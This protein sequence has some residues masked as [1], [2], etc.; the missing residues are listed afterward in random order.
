LK[1]IIKYQDSPI[2][3]PH[4]DEAWKDMQSRLKGN[5]DRS[6]TIADKFSTGPSINTNGTGLARPFFTRAGWIA[7]FSLI[8][9]LYPIHLIDYPTKPINPISSHTNPATSLIPRPADPLY[10]STHLVAGLPAGSTLSIPSSSQHHPTR[11][12]RYKLPATTAAVVSSRASGDARDPATDPGPEFSTQKLS[13][14]THP[15]A[16]DSNTTHSVKSPAPEIQIQQD[17][18]LLLQAGL[19]WTAQVPTGNASSYFAGTNGQSRPYRVLLPALWMH[20]QLEKSLFEIAFDPFYSNMVPARPFSQ[21]ISTTTLPDTSVTISQ[22]KT[23]DKLFGV[24]ASIGYAA[25]LGGNWWAGGGIQTS[26]WTQA[27]ATT[28]TDEVKEPLN[29][30]SMEIRSSFDNTG[31]LSKTD[32]NNFSTF[33]LNLFAQLLYNKGSWHAGFRMGI[34]F[35]PLSKNDG[36]GSP[37]RM[38]FFYRLPLLSR[39]IRTAAPP[40]P[41]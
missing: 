35:N 9:L 39:Q 25:W 32:W 7:L 30:P 8:G 41:E 20:L 17:D 28:R 11:Q 23:L 40:E 38:E 22:S 34:P 27:I 1:E 13:G 2:S 37:L 36:P 12:S 33:Q 14:F 24:S 15:A 18:H 29:N 10:S 26:W 19:Q 5:T 21:G 31:G 3:I 16:R 6:A 4:P